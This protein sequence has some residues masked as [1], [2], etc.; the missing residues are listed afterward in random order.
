MKLVSIAMEVELFVMIKEVVGLFNCLL[1]ERA[2]LMNTCV[3]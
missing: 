1:V 2:F 3:G